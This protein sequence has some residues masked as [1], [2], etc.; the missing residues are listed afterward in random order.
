MKKTKGQQALRI[1]IIVCIA[2]FLISNLYLLCEK[3]LRKNALPMPFGVGMSIVLSGSMEPTLSVDDM[4]IVARQE[5]YETGDVVVYQDGSSL[6]VHRIIAIEGNLVTTQG[7]ANNAPDSP[8]E[9]VCV[10]GKVVRHVENVGGMVRMVKSPVMAFGMMGLA[11]FLL[12]RSFR[13]D[14]DKDDDEISKL[15]AEIQRL[16]EEQ[17][18]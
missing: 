3:T 8:V 7:D 13:K 15:E 14:K 12:E 9:L 16:K 5:T 6:V 4:I 2:I 18:E 17:K 10:K 1:V 11:I